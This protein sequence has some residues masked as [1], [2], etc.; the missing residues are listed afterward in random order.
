MVRGV[1]TGLPVRVISR[2]ALRGL[3]QSA[4]VFS[5]GLP[6]LSVKEGQGYVAGKGVEM[7]VG[8][9]TGAEIA[10]FKSAISQMEFP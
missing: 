7:G 10:A 1:A 4:L 3:A 2:V 6:D 8:R 5:P 9:A